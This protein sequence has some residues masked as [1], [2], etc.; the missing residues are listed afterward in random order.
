ML[1][2]VLYAEGACVPVTYCNTNVRTT[3][4]ALIFSFPTLPDCFRVFIADGK[5]YIRYKNI[6]NGEVKHNCKPVD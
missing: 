2:K 3:Q 5:N 6:T 4:S 1:N